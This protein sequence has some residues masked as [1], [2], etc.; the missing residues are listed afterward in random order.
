MHN[1]S[2]L[3]V[4]MAAVMLGIISGCGKKETTWVD[5]PIVK[6]EEENPDRNSEL[7]SPR[8]GLIKARDAL[9]LPGASR[10]QYGVSKTAKNESESVLTNRFMKPF[11][12]WRDYRSQLPDK[13][14]LIKPDLKN[15]NTTAGEIIKPQIPEIVYEPE[16][17][18]STDILN[19]K[20]R[21]MLLESR[22]ETAVGTDKK[23]YEDKLKLAKDSLAE[24]EREYGKLKPVAPV[25][26][27]LAE[28]DD[29]SN[30][31]IVGKEITVADM[32]NNNITD[33]LAGLKKTFIQHKIGNS[34]INNNQN[35]LIDYHR[36]LQATII[37]I[38]KVLEELGKRH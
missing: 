37:D 4:M 34:S 20:I 6:I 12:K 16:Y 1:K 7:T 14:T 10:K 32:D 21:I 29:S 31:V 8:S 13:F 27:I 26:P 22:L 35:I 9:S 38:D 2:A 28:V 24:S 15:G 33:T 30:Q 11:N 18:K 3:I 36:K 17:P 19:W 5:P 23:Y 25:V